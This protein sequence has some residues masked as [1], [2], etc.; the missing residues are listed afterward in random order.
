MPAVLKLLG[1]P[2]H[3]GPDW[4]QVDVSNQFA[5]IAIRLAEDRLVPP[6]KQV[7]DLLV[8]SIVILTVTGE[9]GHAS[10]D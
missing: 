2:D 7:A 9:A 5:E 8:L 6:L 1:S 10:S 3:L 4:I